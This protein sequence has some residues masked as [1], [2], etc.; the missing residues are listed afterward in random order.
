[1]KG[2]RSKLIVIADLGSGG[3]QQVAS[4]MANYWS[5][6]GVRTGLVTWAGAESDFFKL[7]S[8]VERKALGALPKASNA[9]QGL[10]N[11]L[12]RIKRLRDAIRSFGDATVI[13][14]IAPTNVITVLAS[15]GLG[16]RVVISERNDPGRQSFGP[17]WDLLRR[18]IY[19]RA[20]LVTANSHDALKTLE[21]YVPSDRLAYLPNPIRTAPRGRA[22]RIKRENVFLSVGRLHH[23]KAFDVLIKAFAAI[24]QDLSNWRLVILGEGDER[25]NLERLI[26]RYGLAGRV[27]LAGQVADPFDWYEK[28]G[29]FVLASRYEG[30][31]NALLEAM[32]RG[33]PCIVSDAVPDCR[34]LSAKGATA[35]LVEVDNVDCLARAM[36]TLA[37][38]PGKRKS[39]GTHGREL[40]S[41]QSLDV[42]AP[43]WDAVL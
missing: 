36:K 43:L 34:R 41:S 3:A 31:P 22:K 18:L 11:N 40:A 12:L 6:S 14:F 19:A 20:D 16:R 28:A 29:I 17:L 38:E 42:V 1:M 33:A 2:G 4:S 15:A 30:S 13:S 23:Q 10:L 39:L 37:G 7:D 24:A 35:H 9:V 21:A 32:S 25:Q 26:E 5:A 27:D 8:K